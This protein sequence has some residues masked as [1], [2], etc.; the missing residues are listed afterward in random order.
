MLYRA[1]RFDPPLLPRVPIFFGDAFLFVR[2]VVEPESFLLRSLSACF[3]AHSS[4]CALLAC[5]FRL[6]MLAKEDVQTSTK[7]LKGLG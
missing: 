5:L 7:H 6:D 1:I 2:L 3:L 4:G